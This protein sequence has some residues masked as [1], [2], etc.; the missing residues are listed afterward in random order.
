MISKQLVTVNATKTPAD[1]KSSRQENGTSVAKI[2]ISHLK[3]AKVGEE[4]MN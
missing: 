1:M 2:V 4:C 3:G